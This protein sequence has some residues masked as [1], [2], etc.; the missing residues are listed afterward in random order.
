MTSAA[1]VRIDQIFFGWST[2]GHRLAP[3]NWSFTEADASQR[4]FQRL[5]S[6]LRLLRV[7]GA[8]LPDAA[9]SYFSFEDGLAAVVRR[10]NEGDSAGRNNSHAL[11]G[12]ADALAAEAALGMSLWTGWR[13]DDPSPAIL[14]P[15]LGGALRQATRVAEKRLLPRLAGR[16]ADL[17]G[18]LAQLL[19]DPAGP[20][21]V[22][23]CPDAARPAVLWGLARIAARIRLSVPDWSFS[24]YED[25]HDAGVE[26]L[27][28]FVFLPVLPQTGVSVGRTVVDVEHP[29]E[30]LAPHRERAEQLV[31]DLL[32]G[33]RKSVAAPRRAPAPKS[34]THKAVCI[35]LSSF[36]ADPKPGVEPEPGR[37]PDLPQA[38]GRMRALAR[39]FTDLG[40]TATTLTDLSSRDLGAT[41]RKII[42]DAAET[43]VLV[44]HLFSHG[45]LTPS[46]SLR[47]I[48]ADGEHHEAT[49]VGDWLKRIVDAEAP[50]PMT[51]FLLDVCHGGSVARLFWQP[52][53][54]DEDARA[55]VIAA[56]APDEQAYAG[57]FTD[58]VIRVLG[59][60]AEGRL[61]IDQS[62]RFAP[63]DTIA[64][65]IRRDVLHNA[66]A[67]G[68]F[69]Q[70]VTASRVDI[71]AGLP[72]LPFFPNRQ[73]AKTPR[74]DARTRIDAAAK[75]FLDDLDEALDPVHFLSRAAGHGGP[76]R[77]EL[78]GCFSG[79]RRELRLL[80]PWLNLQDSV[81][82]RVV[83]GSPGAG[84]S[85]LIG[86]L[87]CAA[88]PM[89]RDSTRAVWEAVEQ[90][91][92]LNR[93]MAA[94]HAR[95][96]TPAQIISSVARQLGVLSGVPE[97]TAAGLIATLTVMPEPPVIV[98]DALD[99]AIGAELLMREFLLPLTRV[100][101]ADGNPVRLLV[102]MR[103][104]AEFEPLR[105]EAERQGRVVDLDD[106]DE[107][108]LSR[109]VGAYVRRL[110]LT[111]P[112][113]D[114]LE[115]DGAASTLARAVAETLTQDQANREWG[116]FLVAGLFSGYL[117]NSYAEP[118]SDQ[119][120]AIDVGRSVPRTLPDLLELDLLTRATDVWTRPILVAAAHAKGD[121]MPARLLG[122]A[123]AALDREAPPD[124]QLVLEVLD[125]VRFYLR[126]SAEVD[127][128]TVYRLF[129]QGLADYL[130]QTAEVAPVATGLLDS[131][132]SWAP[133]RRQ[134]P[135]V[136]RWELAEPYLKRHI[137]QHAR[138]AGRL[139]I[140]LADA[141]FLVTADPAVVL[142]ELAGLAVTGP[143]VTAYRRAVSAGFDRAD[144][145]GR[146]QRLALAAVRAGASG[147][148][149]ATA[150]MA[151]HDGVLGWRPLWVRDGSATAIGAD[152]R[153]AVL[154][155][156][157][158]TIIVLDANDG[159]PL[160]GETGAHA[161]P[162]V[163]VAPGQVDDGPGVLSIDDKGMFRRRR[164]HHEY[165]A[166]TS[167][168]GAATR[169]RTS[170]SL[171]GEDCA[172]IVS[173]TGAAAI[174]GV[175]SGRR[176]ATVDGL[177][178]DAECF[179][180]G[181]TAGRILAEAR[182]PGIVTVKMAGGRLTTLE[183]DYAVS[184]VTA[185]AVGD[186]LVIFTAD[187]S[188]TIHAWDLY[189]RRWGRFD[190][191]GRIHRLH[192]TAHGL[193]IV[194]GPGTLTGL[195]F[196]PH[197][198]TAEPLPVKIDTLEL[199]T[200]FGPTVDTQV[201]SASARVGE[202]PDS[203]RAGA[204]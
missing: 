124:T 166:R 106:V 133:A 188:S 56:A 144:R 44:F 101:R 115:H 28:R 69:V 62:F 77:D 180:V 46:G 81:G 202:G 84:K 112:R 17:T 163:A 150:D 15:M 151:E 162:V 55:W 42:D 199:V 68:A 198:L 59:D 164:L 34:K 9:L 89:M 32:Q 29:S 16:S 109:D 203:G 156:A 2:T 169:L 186:V 173:G 113:W 130:K 6:H 92:Y 195:R 19:A 79:R 127:G 65:L 128:T 160:W 3:L 23:G 194:Q 5:R 171:F 143:A 30:Q 87:V 67:A 47:V 138:E 157:E 27:P 99:E 161:G 71:S 149:E 70:R 75:P 18:V 147:L 196:A 26:D 108:E 122:Y 1:A 155:T 204:H 121:G 175:D 183:H 153:W 45:Y 120:T 134:A 187:D 33:G 177:I 141:D 190:L 52:A 8:E 182:R 50:V 102:G 21:S 49:D 36:G 123:A 185:G 61:D 83:T 105:A 14:E 146:T 24:T 154:G 139:A 174:W 165:E 107:R 91:P 76:V 40:F 116:A 111:D 189:G 58:A 48:G 126:Q 178:M 125:T 136:P 148:A 114:R 117:L 179:T 94:V 201:R 7:G 132:R 110:L 86:V 137:A 11:I 98:I 200:T 93:T 88:H 191:A 74:H 167:W 119:A 39:T 168:I 96:R 37:W 103:P 142:P 159:T 31:R 170:P 135:A 100:V 140:L 78:P 22:I 72:E 64:Q 118:I 85:A 10:V 35:G 4:W 57:R 176:L 60:L 158:G 131:V 41:V 12:P 25:R 54:N 172:V 20:I 192:A 43:D 184:A 53:I 104:W 90:A 51:L 13:S 63:L 73:Y 80:S 193:L 82:L 66:T 129:H 197:G 97:P 145:S 38:A 152:E 181:R 95:A